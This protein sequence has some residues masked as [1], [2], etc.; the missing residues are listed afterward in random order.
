MVTAH[1]QDSLVY[2]DAVIIPTAFFGDAFVQVEPKSPW[3]SPHVWYR[4]LIAL[5]VGP[6]P[7]TR[8]MAFAV[9]V[10]ADSPLM[11]GL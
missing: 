1:T 9:T 6:C 4:A 10:S 11:N 8:P 2:A 5:T 3:I 7:I